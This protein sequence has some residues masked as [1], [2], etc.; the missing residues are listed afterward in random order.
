MGTIPARSPRWR[1]QRL[2]RAARTRVAGVNTT[3]Q[4]KNL[5]FIPLDCNLK[6]FLKRSVPSRLWTALRKSWEKLRRLNQIEPVRR[7]NRRLLKFT[8]GFMAFD[9]EIVR[10][11][12][13][14]GFSMTQTGD[15]YS[16]LP[17]VSALQKTIH[18]WSKPS[19][20]I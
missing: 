9:A 20:L 18:R 10:I 7:I 6:R 8:L 15:F 11:F 1:R 5:A 16:P 4:K 17:S 19:E 3:S 12:N 13:Q 14:H 2:G